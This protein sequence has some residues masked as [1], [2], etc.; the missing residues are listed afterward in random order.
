MV[1]SIRNFLAPLVVG[2]ILLG[3]AQLAKYAPP[4]DKIACVEV[5]VLNGSDKPL[6]VAARCGLFEWAVEDVIKLIEGTKRA[7]SARKAGL[8]HY[9]ADASTLDAGSD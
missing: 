8:K 5:E 1:R 9:A 4:P 7:E 6:D 2:A 3:C